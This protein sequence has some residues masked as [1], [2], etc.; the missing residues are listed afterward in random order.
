MKKKKTTHSK[1]FAKLPSVFA[2][3][4]LSYYLRQARGDLSELAEVKTLKTT[5][6]TS[7]KNIV[8]LIASEYMGEPNSLGKKLLELFL[9]ALVNHRIKPKAIILINQ[10]VKLTCHSCP[11]LANLTLLSEQEI[12][13]LVCD[14][15][16]KELK[17]DKT[18]KIGRLADMNIICDNLL[19]AWKVITL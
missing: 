13:I 19:T 12:D 5:P 14:E 17:A 16:V 18:V 9:G 4:D 11:A 6:G 15:S 3:K 2:E 8:I 7:H 10:A 1:N